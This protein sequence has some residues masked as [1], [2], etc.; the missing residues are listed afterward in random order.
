MS[1]SFGEDWSADNCLRTIS[2]QRVSSEVKEDAL[3]TGFLD[4][5]AM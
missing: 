4:S 2:M 5:G 1:K 3:I